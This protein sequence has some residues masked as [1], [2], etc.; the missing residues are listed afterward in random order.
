MVMILCSLLFAG[1]DVAGPGREFYF[2]RDGSLMR[3]AA[4]GAVTTFVRNAANPSI[5][6]SGKRIAFWR[7]RDLRIVD[8]ATKVETLVDRNALGDSRKSDSRFYPTWTSDSQNLIV[9]RCDAVKV[10]FPGKPRESFQYA[11]ES[12]LRLWSIYRYVARSSQR[13]GADQAVALSHR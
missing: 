10:N 13:H 5:S 3:H 12:P 4:S 11:L 8:V 1:T 2:V 7:G 9:S 6:P